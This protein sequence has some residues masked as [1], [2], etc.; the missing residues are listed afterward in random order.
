[1][2]TLP[3]GRLKPRI[4]VSDGRNWMGRNYCYGIVAPMEIA[5]NERCSG[6][7]VLKVLIFDAFKL[8]LGS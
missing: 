5:G 2:S 6:Q 4:M 8:R 1:M 3:Y 7:R